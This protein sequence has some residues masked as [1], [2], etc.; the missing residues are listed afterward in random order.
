MSQALHT[1][2]RAPVPPDAGGD[3]AALAARHGL[4]VSGA[5]P[6]LV[7]YVRQL[8]G[9]RQFILAFSRAKLT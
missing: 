7:E 4:S 5:R 8:W 1:P 9:R 3:L 2:P 6:S